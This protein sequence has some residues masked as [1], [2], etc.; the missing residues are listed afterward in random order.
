MVYSSGASIVGWWVIRLNVL[1][2][3]LDVELDGAVL[4]DGSAVGNFRYR[5]ILHR[6]AHGFVKGKS[7]AADTFRKPAHDEV[8]QRHHFVVQFD[9]LGL[10]GQKISGLI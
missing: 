3:E 8:V 4:L 9:A 10:R 6:R 5:H 2:I 7:R 1:N